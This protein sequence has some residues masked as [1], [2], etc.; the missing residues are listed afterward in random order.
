MRSSIILKN[1]FSQPRIVTHID[2]SA[3]NSLTH[4]YADHLN[5]NSV[6]VDICSSWI[7]H[8]PSNKVFKKVVGIGMHILNVEFQFF[9]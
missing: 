7:S 8:L 4:F 2:E 1:N 3:I 9:V 5:N 6:V